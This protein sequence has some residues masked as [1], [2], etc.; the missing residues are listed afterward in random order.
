VADTHTRIRYPAISKRAISAKLL[1][2]SLSEEMRVLYVAMTRAR[3]RLIMTYGAQNLQKQL[4]E[5]FQHFC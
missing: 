5:Q 1:S 4:Q 2:E 3:D